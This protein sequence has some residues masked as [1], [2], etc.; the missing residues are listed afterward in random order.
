M[1]NG[2]L[3]IVIMFK[4]ILVATHGTKG[5]QA[6]EDLAVDLA[7]E[8]GAIL[9]CI[10]VVN[11]DWKW[12]TG[13]DWLNTSASRN[14]FARHVE[15]ELGLEAEVIRKRISEKSSRR[16]VSV[17]FENVVGNPGKM[18][19][20]AASGAGADLIVMGARQPRQDQGFKSRI[21]WNKLLGESTVPIILAPPVR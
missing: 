10:H 4:K 15:N 21:D 16:A 13:D 7:R 8:H 20:Q 11:E 12:M 9:H 1:I 18:I 19:L 17:A 5:A 6:A 2:R 3:W 14:R